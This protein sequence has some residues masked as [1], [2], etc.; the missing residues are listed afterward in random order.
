[1]AAK[2]EKEKRPS[3]LPEQ[4]RLVPIHAV[5]HECQST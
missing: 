2:K 4:G 1:M 3:F 5:D